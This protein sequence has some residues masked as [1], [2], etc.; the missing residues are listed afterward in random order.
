MRNGR[1]AAKVKP[2]LKTDVPHPSVYIRDELKA[3]RWSRDRLAIE[4]GGDWAIN[5]LAIDLYFIVGPTDAKCRI[6]T[7]SARQFSRAFGVSATLFLNLEKAW[8][9][10][11]ARREAATWR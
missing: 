3:R 8:L 6:G 7:E 9:K 2:V 5:R 1:E 10:S 4:M 11:V